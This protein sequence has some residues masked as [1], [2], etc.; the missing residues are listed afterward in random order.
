MYRSAS[1]V[2]R[3]RH[4]LFHHP[5]ILKDLSNRAP[6]NECST[7]RRELLHGEREKNR[8]V[9]PRPLP[10]HIS[11]PHPGDLFSERDGESAAEMPECRAGYQR[12]KVSGR[13]GREMR[14]HIRWL[15]ALRGNCDISR[16][17]NMVSLRRRG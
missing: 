9:L 16:S 15:K 10:D 7:E 2:A 4:P 13:R 11:R 8:G 1:A 12:E 14:G 6:P 17:A 3:F 5:T